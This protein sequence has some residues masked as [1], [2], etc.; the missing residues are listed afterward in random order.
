MPKKTKQQIL[1][2][3]METRQ[4][5]SSADVIKFGLAIYYLRAD[6]T[7]RDFL[8]KGL[9]KRIDPKDYKGKQALYEWI[10]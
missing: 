6:R 7:K 4:R 10:G 3:W 1:I 5:F 9:I 2:D 8:E